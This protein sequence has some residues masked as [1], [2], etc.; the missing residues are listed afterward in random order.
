MTQS[1]QETLAGI[2]ARAADVIVVGAGISGL[3]AAYKLQQSGVSCIVLEASGRVGGPTSTNNHFNSELHPRTHGL[4]A[5][6]G[7]LD[8]SRPRQGKTI[9]ESFEPFEHHEQPALDAKDAASL[10]QVQ[11]ILDTLSRR[12]HVY[13]AE[14]TVQELISLYGATSTVKNLANMWTRT[15]FGLSCHNVSASQFLSH[16]ASCG[17]LVALLDNINGCSDDFAISES[18]QQIAA[19]LAKRLSPGTI[20]PDQ[21]VT[22]VEATSG[23]SCRIYTESGDVFVGSKV[24]LAGSLPMCGTLQIT[25]PIAM[26]AEW[27]SLRDEQGFSTSVDIVFDHPWWQQRG[28]SG[29]AQGLTGPISQVRPSGI[30][31]DNGLVYSLSCQISGEQARGMWLWLMSDEE[32]ETLIMQHLDIIFGGDKIPR[33]VQII[34]KDEDPLVSGQQ[35][36]NIAWKKVGAAGEHVW[37]AP[38]GNI[39]FAGADTSIMCKG[40]VEGALETGE[41]AAAEIVAVL[42]TLNAVEFAPRL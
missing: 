9:L 28:L 36:L 10:C 8:E 18:S 34:E 6:F 11:A 41:R 13:Q 38:E 42:G 1:A 22:H 21:K 23:T 33:A 39:H 29:Y 14:M 35:S 24:A 31:M 5:E 27:E 2:P 40:H 12:R 7:L 32:R 26:A 15:V 16:C 4:A 17:G 20:Q 3:Y 25:P 19:A 30:E 37:A